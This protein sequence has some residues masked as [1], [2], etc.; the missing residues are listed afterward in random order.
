M[1]P[2]ELQLATFHAMRKFYT[3]SHC[4][5]AMWRF[6]FLTAILRSYGVRA[7]A[8]WERSNRGFI[9]KLKGLVRKLPAQAQARI[10]QVVSATPRPVRST[11]TLSQPDGRA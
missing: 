10:S 2:I 6:R 4:L 3:Y 1:S 9:E 5:R 8:Q 11:A 7:I